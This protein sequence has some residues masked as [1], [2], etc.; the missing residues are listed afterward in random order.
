MLHNTLKHLMQNVWSDGEE[1]VD[2][3]EHFPKWVEDGLETS[4]TTGRIEQMDI[5]ISQMVGIQCCIVIT[6]RGPG[7]VTKFFRMDET[8]WAL[9][10]I[11]ACDE[12]LFRVVT[13][14]HPK[15]GMALTPDP[16]PT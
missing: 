15:Y 3:R 14:K 7:R 8:F 12:R 13:D 5:A 10:V 4:L 2:E 9:A 1:D 11:C 16:I 6:G